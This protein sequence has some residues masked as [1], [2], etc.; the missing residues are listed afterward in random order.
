MYCASR[1]HCSN[2]IRTPRGGPKR[3]VLDELFNGKSANRLK[4]CISSLPA[5]VLPHYCNVVIPRKPS[6]MMPV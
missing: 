4:K 5:Q 6:L 3:L 1:R 2:K